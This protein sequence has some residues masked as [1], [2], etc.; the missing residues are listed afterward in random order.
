M[1]GSSGTYEGEEKSEQGLSVG[2]LRERDYLEDVCVDGSVIL[3]L[4][5]RK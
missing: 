4:I 1:D 5:L 2:N 3:K